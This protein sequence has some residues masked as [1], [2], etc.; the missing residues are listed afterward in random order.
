MRVKAELQ[1]LDEPVR[2]VASTGLTSQTVGDA[3]SAAKKAKDR[4]WRAPIIS[5]LRDPDR[6]A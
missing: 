2:P 3:D 4:D 6:G 1:V 5:Y